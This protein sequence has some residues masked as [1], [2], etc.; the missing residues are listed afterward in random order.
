MKVT[1]WVKSTNRE[2]QKCALLCARAQDSE[3]KRRFSSTE[4]VQAAAPESTEGGA[5]LWTGV[6]AL[7]RSLSLSLSYCNSI[8]LVVSSQLYKHYV[9]GSKPKF[10]TSLLYTSYIPLNSLDATVECLVNNAFHWRKKTPPWLALQKTSEPSE[11]KHYKFAQLRP[12][13][14]NLDDKCDDTSPCTILSLRGLDSLTSLTLS[15]AIK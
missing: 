2:W 9:L 7:A 10:L 15:I 6:Q 4:G 8:T 11:S 1:W 12:P 3:V 13:Y 5:R 14:T